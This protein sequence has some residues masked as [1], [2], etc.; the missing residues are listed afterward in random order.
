MTYKY[1]RTSWPGSKTRKCPK[2]A[3]YG[4]SNS[5]LED[6]FQMVLGA[7]AENKQD[8]DSDEDEQV[9]VCY[10]FCS[11][12]LLRCWLAGPLRCCCCPKLRVLESHAQI[13]DEGPKDSGLD[14]DMGTAAIDSFQSV[15]TVRQQTLTLVRFSLLKTGLE[16]SG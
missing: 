14:D 9:D 13:E 7:E 2:V 6:V 8:I 15:L 16:K 3:E 4:F 5:S 10:S 1:W 12:D 11:T